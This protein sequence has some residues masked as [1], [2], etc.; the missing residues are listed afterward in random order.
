[1]PDHADFGLDRP[2]DYGTLTYLDDKGQYHEEKVVS[3]IGDYS[4]MYAGIYDAIVNHKEKPVKD[5]E[6]ILQL[7]MLETAIKQIKE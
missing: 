6:T 4:R 3:E 7:E 2:E 1:M 5:E